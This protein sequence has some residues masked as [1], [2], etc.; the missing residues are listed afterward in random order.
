MSADFR[1]VR[2]HT[3]AAADTLGRLLEAR[4]FTVGQDI[5]FRRGEYATTSPT[6]SS[7]LTH[8]LTHVV[9]QAALPGTGPGV[10]QRGR[11]KGATGTGQKEEEKKEDEEEEGERRKQEKQ[12]VNKSGAT[13]SGG[14]KLSNL[15]PPSSLPTTSRGVHP[16]EKRRTLERTAGPPP[17]Q[18]KTGLKEKTGPKG[19]PLP[20]TLTAKKVIA[21]K[22][23]EVQPSVPPPFTTATT[24]EIGGLDAMVQHLR[25]LEDAPK[26]D[27]KGDPIT[28]GIAVINVNHLGK[29]VFER[30]KR[31]NLNWTEAQNALVNL[32]VCLRTA[33]IPS[34]IT[35]DGAFAAAPTGTTSGTKKAEEQETEAKKQL[36]S[37]RRAA[38]R[39]SRES[40]TTDLEKL[41][42]SFME[43]Y[44]QRGRAV[45]DDA[46]LLE[47]VREIENYVEVV[48]V[49]RQGLD[50]ERYAKKQALRK[51][52]FNA[53]QQNAEAIKTSAGSAAEAL[54]MLHIDDQVSKAKGLLAER[55]LLEEL[56]GHPAVN[57]V[58]GNEL[59]AGAR[60]LQTDEHGNL[61]IDLGPKI[62]ARGKGGG[63]QTEY[64][65]GIHKSGDEQTR[66][67]QKRRA[68][69]QAAKLSERVKQQRASLAE[70]KIP[71]LPTVP[72]LGPKPALEPEPRAT[73]RTAK[74]PSAGPTGVAPVA[75][76][77]AFYV[78]SEGSF[79]ERP[80][81]GPWIIPWSKAAKTYRGIVVRRYR[82]QGQEFWVGVIHTTPKGKDLARKNIWTQIDRPMSNLQ[83]LA[84]ELGI[85]LILGG[86]FY[87]QPE[88][89]V[90]GANDFPQ[91]TRT[92]KADD[93]RS[94]QLTNLARNVYLQ[95]VQEDQ[96][97]F[98]HRRRLLDR[99]KDYA[100]NLDPL[101]DENVA[102]KTARD[103]FLARFNRFNKE[104]RRGPEDGPGRAIAQQLGVAEPGGGAN[105]A[106][107]AWDAWTA[108]TA[109][110]KSR[111]PDVAY[112][113][114]LAR[115]RKA[116]A[117]DDEMDL[118]TASSG[119]GPETK[120][121][122]VPAATPPDT[123]PELRRWQAYDE[124]FKAWLQRN[125]E[126]GPK[127][128]AALL[129]KEA[130]NNKKLKML[131]S[132]TLFSGDEQGVDAYRNDAALRITFE[133]QLEERGLRLVDMT[134]TTNAVPKGRRLKREQLADFFVVNDMWT[135]AF[136]GFLDLVDKQLR[137]MPKNPEAWRFYIKFS[138]HVAVVMVV[139]TSRTRE[140]EVAAY[141]DRSPQ[142]RL[143]AGGPARRTAFEKA[144]HQTLVSL[145]RLYARLQALD[146]A[147]KSDRQVNDLRQL[148]LHV[149]RLKQLYATGKEP[150]WETR[151]ELAERPYK[152]EDV[153][154][155]LAE[156]RSDLR[157]WYPSGAGDFFDDDYDYTGTREPAL[158]TSAAR[159]VPADPL[160]H[161]S[162]TKGSGITIGIAP[163]RGST[164][165]AVESTVGEVAS[166]GSSSYVSAL[167]HLLSS[168]EA[169]FDVLDPGSIPLLPT[170]PVTAP[171]QPEPT[172]PRSEEGS[173]DVDA[174]EPSFPTR[175]ADTLDTALDRLRLR[176][177][178]EQ[179]RLP[180]LVDQLRKGGTIRPR[181]VKALVEELMASG[182]DNLDP[183]RR[184]E[185]DIADLLGR[186]LDR[187]N[188]RV[189]APPVAVLRLP[190]ATE[191]GP[192]PSIDAAL[193]MAK[194]GA[195][196]AGPPTVL[197][198]VLERFPISDAAQHVVNAPDV[199]QLPAQYL[200]S[201]GAAKAT[202]HL[203][204]VVH[205]S[206]TGDQ[207]YYTSIGRTSG[208]PGQ[209]YVHDD[210]RDT[211]RRVLT[212]DQRPPDVDTGHVYVYV[213][214]DP[215]PLF[216]PSL[217][218]TTQTV[219]STSSTSPPD[220]GS[221]PPTTQDQ[222]GREKK[223]TAALG[224]L[225]RQSPQHAREALEN[226][227][228]L[229]TDAEWETK[230]SAV[231]VAGADAAG[232]ERQMATQKAED[233][234]AKK[235]AKRASKKMGKD[236]EP[237][238][239]QTK[240][241]RSAS[242]TQGKTTSAETTPPAQPP[243]TG[244]QTKKTKKDVSPPFD[245]RARAQRPAIEFDSWR[246]AAYEVLPKGTLIRI[247]GSYPELARRIYELQANW[248]P[249]YESDIPPHFTKWVN[250]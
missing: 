2:V 10:I 145:R 97:R 66:L 226:I 42:N 62:E 182:L 63:T 18:E 80:T 194:P 108:A 171:P 5:F 148:W 223:L 57:I 22:T 204:H 117:P 8:E 98:L 154:K 39:A 46:D 50:H 60:L 49:I 11:I 139:S 186:L 87:L 166:I 54:K 213:R 238:K 217:L 109:S 82:Q 173:M 53:L 35:A 48:E 228:G 175:P 113:Q 144:D 116:T 107:V 218:A 227:L 149:D 196:F 9:Q 122:T 153:A 90:K 1:N 135:V 43:K 59:N 224:P 192:L 170:A 240:R 102:E 121:G 100:E 184:S 29:N 83:A 225:L 106:S 115:L 137:P 37:F 210:A 14:K 126:A 246:D 26:F 207:G 178:L 76:H 64:Y 232:L 151:K 77:D 4:A 88:A 250:K 105:S 111:Q 248:V 47:T 104:H 25:R 118:D 58:I 21:T 129:G 208:D 234:K 7:T 69:N 38:I 71:K 214:H 30:A 79:H 241:R 68:R 174:D 233:E 81:A 96:D 6:P 206:G 187:P 141:F 197:T 114:L 124:R 33:D 243:A 125:P 212:F 242:E 209:W 75:L 32:R 239:T 40:F 55:L 245:A 131:T 27:P 150:M 12:P 140:R 44:K 99:L 56:P 163:L 70:F 86:D 89:V 24:T 235:K 247:T 219:V 200:S 128:L 52:L 221:A 78:D 160:P 229:A 93:I 92:E 165:E 155:E 123:N 205:R 156:L 132:S 198:I 215:Q 17:G 169:F 190:V 133:K 193:A 84:D 191:G 15:P 112:Q 179:S 220:P 161:A 181:A 101:A 94:A 16:T 45:T 119:V 230:M 61:R 51:R 231:V 203:R 103:E 19:K 180:G 199:L 216:S 189:S 13:P 127:D 159:S 172:T 134:F 183:R 36:R 67:D 176:S 162:S 167:L 164:T 136:S 185:L 168:D 95:A 72:S 20:T 147:K 249:D 188:V 74:G 143:G 244:H 41:V 34:L 31:Q 65:G 23:T 138:D 177:F 110:D 146:A 237:E 157:R 211:G 201:E 120:G 152:V 85:P 222:Q 28:A 3:G 73:E 142:P 236:E 158:T 202:Y 195:P 130:E 91:G